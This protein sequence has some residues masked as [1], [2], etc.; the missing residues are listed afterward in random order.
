MQFDWDENKNKRNQVKHG[1][2]FN[3]AKEVFADPRALSTQDRHIDGEERWQTMGL[4]NGVLLLLV[5][6]KYQD[7]GKNEF[8]RIISARKTTKHERKNYEQNN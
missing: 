1:V 2:S 4:V 6:H 5:V 3:L 8:I 7:S